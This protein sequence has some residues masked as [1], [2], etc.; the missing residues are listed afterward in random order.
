MKIDY[1]TKRDLRWLSKEIKDLKKKEILNSI[2]NK[3]IIIARI[4]KKPVGSLKYCLFWSRFPMIEAIWV[5]EKYQRKGI[6]KKLFNSLERIAKTKRQK[7]VMSSYESKA[8]HS[9]SFHKS[10]G[11]KIA[12]VINNFK[13]IQKDKEVIVIKRIK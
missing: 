3:E 5:E 12:G 8:K 9:A 7:I 6:G 2:K 1:A 4:N 11:F 13:P 10:L